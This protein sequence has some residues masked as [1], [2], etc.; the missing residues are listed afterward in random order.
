MNIRR[1]ENTA[2]INW[3]PSNALTHEA[4]IATGIQ[5]GK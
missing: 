5:L 4:A 2:H 1:V 3:Q